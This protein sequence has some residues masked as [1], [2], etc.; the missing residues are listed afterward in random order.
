[1]EKAGCRNG[2]GNHASRLLEL[3]V[4]GRSHV[5]VRD[6]ALVFFEMKQMLRVYLRMFSNIHHDYCLE[7]LILT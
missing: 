5:G 3:A 2:S 4:T 6:H 1:M 7:I